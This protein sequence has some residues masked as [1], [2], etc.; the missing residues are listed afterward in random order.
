[1]IGEV[2]DDEREKGEKEGD[3][4]HTRLLYISQD[5]GSSRR[6]GDDTRNVF[7]PAE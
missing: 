1:V 6:K 4:L 3:C 5:L 2:V 7:M